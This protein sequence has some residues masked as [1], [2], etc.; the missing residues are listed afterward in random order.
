MSFT[1]KLRHISETIL[2][3]SLSQFISSVAVVQS[4][5]RAHLF[6]TP[7]TAARLAS[8]SFIITRSLLRLM[9]I[10]LVMPS[11]HLILCDPLLFLPLI[12]PS[13][14]GFSNE[15]AFHIRWSKNWR[16]T[17]SPSN[18]YSGLISFRTDCFDLLS[19]GLSGVL[20]HHTSKTSILQHSAFFKV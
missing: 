13:T 18:E 17:I 16:F 19:K 3:L 14:R 8:L 5:S 9:S 11:H 15:L 1:F 7:W 20:Q 6:L 10:D 4:L 12:F 2:Y